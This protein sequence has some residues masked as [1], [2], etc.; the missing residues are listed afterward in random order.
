MFGYSREDV[1]EDL[2][3]KSINIIIP[4][5]YNNYHNLFLNRFNDNLANLEE[6]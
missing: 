2:L 3:K 1:R 6:F 5:L 4:N